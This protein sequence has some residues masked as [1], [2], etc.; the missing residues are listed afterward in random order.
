MSLLKKI[1]NR[2]HPV[3]RPLASW[4]LSKTRTFGYKNIKV[5]VLPGVFHP[6]LFL[7]TKILLAYLET[8]DINNRSMLELGAGTGLISIYCSK[9]GSLVSASDISKAALHCIQENAKINNVHLSVIESDLFDKID[10]TDFDIIIIN[11]PYY[12]KAVVSEKDMPWFCGEHFEYFEKLFY[13]LKGKT[14]AL[15]ALMILSE[16]CALEQIQ[17]IAHKNSLHLNEVYSS[18]KM[19]ERNAIYRISE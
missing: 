14:S 6:G 5:K 11:P 16:D 10:V 19:G 18:S 2:F 9:K 4:Y 3:L 15:E 1:L 12:P 7:S 13:Q 17:S 8:R